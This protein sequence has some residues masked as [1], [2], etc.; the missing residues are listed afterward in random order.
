MAGWTSQADECQTFC[1]ALTFSLGIRGLA[2]STVH[3]RIKRTTHTRRAI[4]LKCLLRTDGEAG[5]TDEYTQ[6]AAQVKQ[7]E[8]PPRRWKPLA[9]LVYLT[10]VL[11]C[12]VRPTGSIVSSQRLMSLLAALDFFLP[13]SVLMPTSLTRH[14]E[15]SSKNAFDSDGHLFNQL[16][17]KRTWT[18]KQKNNR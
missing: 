11:R 7:D 1:R 5:K 2:N 3:I 14:R 4:V 17:T 8:N 18:T 12:I 10:S 6:T 15:R 16:C 9:S 13:D